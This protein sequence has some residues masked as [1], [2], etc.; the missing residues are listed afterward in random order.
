[1]SPNRTSMDDENPP[2]EEGPRNQG[3]LGRTISQIDT[4]T[5]ILIQFKDLTVDVKITPKRLKPWENHQK[6]ILAGVSGS[7]R[8]TE[9]VALMGASGAGKSTLLNVLSRRNISHG[10]AVTFNGNPATVLD[11]RAH[12]AYIQQEDLFFGKLTVREHM[13]SQASL[14]LP[15]STTEA[16]RNEIVSEILV[17]LGLTK[18]EHARVGNTML[19]DGR[20][21][22]GGEKKRLNIASELLTSPSVLFADEPT[23]GLDSFVAMSAIEALR[24][25][26]DSGRTIIC[27][28]H[29]PSARI[30]NMFDRVLFMAEGEIIF[31]GPINAAVEWF[32]RLGHR[33]PSTSNPADFLIR[34]VSLT[35]ENREEKLPILQ[36]WAEKWTEESDA[37][38]H[39]WETG[40]KGEFEAKRA[41]MVER[42]LSGSLVDTGGLEELIRKGT[43]DA[44]RER[45]NTAV[46]EIACSEDYSMKDA[47]DL[48][49]PTMHI[50]WF[51]QTWVLL[52]RAALCTS[53]DP[54]LLYARV[55]QTVVLGLLLGLLFLRLD[56]TAAGGRSRLGASFSVLLNQG[57]LGSLAVTQT[58]P[59]DKPI[60]QREYE[61]GIVKMGAFYVAK[62]TA[63]SPVQIIFP[64]IF[65]TLCWYLIGMNDDPVRWLISMAVMLL[66]ANAALGIGYLASGLANNT[67]M[68]LVI[69]QLILIPM[70]VFSGFML[71]L[72]DASKFWV[73]IIYISPFKYGLSAYA[74]TAFRGKHLAVEI[75][76]EEV[77]VPG[78]DFIEAAIGIKV[79]DFA[80][81]MVML[82]VLL[83][84]FRIVAAGGLVLRAKLEKNTS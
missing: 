66:A 2:H 51:K 53:R 80:L 17:K 27:T 48:T 19:G 43:A 49:K 31:F 9:M 81:D 30:F 21:I 61:S 70:I 11:A 84:V 13:D 75:G 39:D 15:A 7:I 82:A 59:E 78:E 41:R 40:L 67:Q 44:R 64:A 42:R 71:D 52:K 76:G 72:R 32:G 54:I 12:A 4:F 62:T 22:S 58:F 10:G 38:L 65:H 55:M 63:D 45:A 36:G 5:P 77:M 20:G 14:R 18:C 74:T 68:A 69:A 34:V 25:L 56:W 16:E 57:I 73:W 60:V 1:M 28:I 23:T 83:V 8:P 37:F 79:S 3:T 24:E 35:D 29:Q 6:R 50:S 33:C 26:A 47:D 46:V